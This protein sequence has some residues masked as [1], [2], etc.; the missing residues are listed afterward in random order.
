MP[1]ASMPATQQA[2]KK[3]FPYL[4]STVHQSQL[5][6]IA[7]LTAANGSVLMSAR[8]LAL[9]QAATPSWICNTALKVCVD[10]RCNRVIVTAA[11]T[12]AN[13]L[14]IALFMLHVYWNLPL[15]PF[16]SMVSPTFI[17][18]IIWVILPLGYTLMTNS[19][20]PK[21]SSSVTGV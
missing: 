11:L 7:G 20:A 21:V 15:G 12:V 10:A 4:Y 2:G 6:R 9:Q 3:G 16:I 13:C 19:T 5:Q 1:P 18:S 17:L 8:H 14:P